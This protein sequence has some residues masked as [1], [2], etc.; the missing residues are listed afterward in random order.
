MK[1]IENSLI[2]YWEK[3]EG[4]YGERNYTYPV[5]DGELII[6]SEGE[7]DFQLNSFAMEIAKESLPDIC[8]TGMEI[9]RKGKIA[10]IGF[11]EFE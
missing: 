2:R 5:I 3:F 7:T 8:I 4:E 11:T 9:H 6:E 10:T 1:V